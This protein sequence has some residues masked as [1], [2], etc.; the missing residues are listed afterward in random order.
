MRYLL[1]RPLPPERV[2]A[3]QDLGVDRAGA[4]S[5]VKLGAYMALLEQVIEEL[6]A[7][8]SAGDLR[9]LEEP[10]FIAVINADDIHI[11][12]GVL[13]E[14]VALYAQLQV[15]GRRRLRSR[16]PAAGK[17]DRPQ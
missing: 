14:H 3:G 11:K 17:E 13:E 5:E 16:A 6:V 8:Q 4:G 10:G 9:H 15:A 2:G 1:R 7:Q 12:V